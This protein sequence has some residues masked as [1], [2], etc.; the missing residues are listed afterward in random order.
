LQL[1]RSSVT[2]L[3]SRGFVLLRMNRFRAAIASFDGALTIRPKLASSLFGRGL[4]KLL[5][6]DRTAARDIAA[7]KFIEPG[8][9]A[10]F[11]R[12]GIRVRSSAPSGT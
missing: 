4:A 5:I 2:A 10:R 7:A 3:D 9:E 8:I 11:L 6:H 1:D 12:Y